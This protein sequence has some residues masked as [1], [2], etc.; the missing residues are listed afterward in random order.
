MIEKKSLRRP[1]S[2]FSAAIAISL[3][4][5]LVPVAA[6]NA[7]TTIQSG[8]AAVKTASTNGAST[9][10]AST[11][12]ASSS[13]AGT[14]GVNTTRATDDTD[15]TEAV[16]ADL[17]GPVGGANAPAPVREVNVSTTAQL[18]AAL[19]AAAPGDRITLADGRYLGKFVTSNSGTEA[20]PITLIGSRKAVLTTGSTRKG[21]GLHVTG[22]YWNLSGFTV[23]TAHKGI[24]LDAA[25]YSIIDGVDVGDIGQE[26]IHVRHS[27]SHVIVRNSLVHD[28]GTVSQ[29]F[30]EGIYLGSSHKNWSKVMGSASLADQSDYAIVENNTITNTAA[31][32]ID[33]KEGTIGGQLLNNTF[34]N[35][36]WS[37]K[38]SADS[39]VDVKGNGYL[40]SGNRGSQTINDGFQVH[41]MMV[42][43][44]QR[45]TFEN[46]SSTG[47]VP[48]Y[49]V[50][51]VWGSTDNVVT[52]APSTATL[53]LTN[54][55]CS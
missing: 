50:R 19:A 44:G 52:C 48:G 1:I 4:L 24:V 39:W 23:T 7:H 38:N 43:W 14:S 47:V 45:N 46:N 40:I 13:G 33:V 29:A 12:G 16:D 53:G 22:E 11:T 17:E 31:E 15:T 9:T 54:I 6:A 41:K 49:L 26:A 21:Y 25:S 27:S 3:G 55:P 36:A 10:G 32:G 8:R 2:T 42:G 51:I 18:K 35:D 5:I 30:G 20:A 28:T 37:G 34:L